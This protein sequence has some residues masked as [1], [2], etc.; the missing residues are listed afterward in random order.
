MKR[1]LWTLPVYIHS[2]RVSIYVRIRLGPVGGE[3]FESAP[4]G[5]SDAPTL[6]PEE[7]LFPGCEGFVPSLAVSVVVVGLL[8]EI[9]GCWNSVG[10]MISGCVWCVVYICVVSLFE[11]SKRSVWNHSPPAKPWSTKIRFGRAVWKC[12]SIVAVFVSGFQ[13]CVCV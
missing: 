9:R 5:C 4:T 10:T 6:N 13:C 2:T 12:F 8:R 3:D 11:M 1:R 7:C